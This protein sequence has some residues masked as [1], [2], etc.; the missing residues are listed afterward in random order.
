MFTLREWSSKRF[1]IIAVRVENVFSGR[2]TSAAFTEGIFQVSESYTSA[3]SNNRYGI[4][5]ITTASASGIE[6]RNDNSFTL[7]QGSI[8]DVMGDM[9]FIVADNS[10]L[11][12]APMVIKEEL[13]EVRE[14]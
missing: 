12:F 7:S 13:H 3:S 4:M 11:R 2:E 9:K 8:I 5:E 1:P 14:Q 6:M 10:T